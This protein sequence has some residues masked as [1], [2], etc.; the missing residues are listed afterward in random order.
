MENTQKHFVGNVAQ[1]AVIKKDGKMLVCRGVGD[2]VWEFPGGRLHADETPHDGLTREIKEELG[3]AITIIRPIHVCRS[4]HNQSKS[5][6]VFVGYECTIT[7]D[8]HITMDQT[9]LEELRWML[10]EL[11]VSLWAQQLKTPY[12]VS[13]K[14]VEKFLAEI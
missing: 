11:R 13:F 10:E 3:I 1:K 6:Q 12:P 2:S 8:Q 4:F 9:E 14:R 5:W 7:D